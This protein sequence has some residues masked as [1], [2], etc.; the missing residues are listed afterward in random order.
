MNKSNS[1]PSKLTYLAVYKVVV[2]ETSEKH[3]P[4][5]QTLSIRDKD[6]SYGQTPTPKMPL[7]STPSHSHSP[8]NPKHER[9]ENEGKQN[10]HKSLTEKKDPDSLLAEVKKNFKEKY[11]DGLRILCTNIR[12]IKSKTEVLTYRSN[13]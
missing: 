10:K 1:I 7:P 3:I 11:P 4:R 6:K 2:L 8:S 9:S 12:S 13:N 5:K